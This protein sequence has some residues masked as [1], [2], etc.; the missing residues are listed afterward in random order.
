VDEGIGSPDHLRA[1]VR[2]I[3]ELKARYG[4]L[5]DVRVDELPR[6]VAYKSR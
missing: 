6:A 2:R 5:S 4:L 1:S 3:L